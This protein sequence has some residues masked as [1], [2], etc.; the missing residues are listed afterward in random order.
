MVAHY[1]L[2]TKSCYLQLSFFLTF[3]LLFLF[4]LA[5]LLQDK[6]SAVATCGSLGDSSNRQ[7]LSKTLS[8]IV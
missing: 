6:N 7:F 8:E 3:C 5:L 4:F 2:L 1:A